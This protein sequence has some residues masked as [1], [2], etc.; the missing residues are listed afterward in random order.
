MREKIAA[1]PER[2]ETPD[3][4]N[5]RELSRPVLRRQKE[6]MQAVDGLFNDSPSR[7]KRLGVSEQTLRN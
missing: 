2:P 3:N 7:L 1:N 6:S 5:C 4:Y